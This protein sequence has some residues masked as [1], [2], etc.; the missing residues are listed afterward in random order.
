MGKRLRLRWLLCLLVFVSHRHENK[1]WVYIVYEENQKKNE[2]RK[3]KEKKSEKRKN[4][5][6]K[7]KNKID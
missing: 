6:K 5:N 3:K 1:K 7:D 4:R 2:K